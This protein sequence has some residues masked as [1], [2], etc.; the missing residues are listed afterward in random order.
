MIW[1]YHGKKLGSQC[2]DEL[3]IRQQ[4]NPYNIKRE[5]H[6]LFLCFHRVSLGLS[7]GRLLL[8]S[9]CNF[10]ERKLLIHG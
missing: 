4:Y 10:L 7:Q 1:R 9:D 8:L 6:A 3:L 5:Q 2:V